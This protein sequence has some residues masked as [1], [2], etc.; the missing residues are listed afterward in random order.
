MTIKPVK[1]DK[2]DSEGTPQHRDRECL[3]KISSPKSPVS[4]KMKFR[5]TNFDISILIVCFF[6]YDILIVDSTACDR[7]T[8]QFTKYFVQC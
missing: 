4:C 1:S 6:F 7:S 2:G 8:E 5:T 3:S